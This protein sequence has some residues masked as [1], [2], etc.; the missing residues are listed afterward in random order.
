VIA[1]DFWKHVP[2]D[3]FV[4]RIEKFYE[5]M[6]GNILRIERL[7]MVRWSEKSRNLEDENASYHS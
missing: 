2:I 6:G 3:K 1:M 5:G 7:S 4:R